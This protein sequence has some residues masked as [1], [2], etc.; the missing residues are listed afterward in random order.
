[1]SLP[2]VPYTTLHDM[3]FRKRSDIPWLWNSTFES[4]HKILALIAYVRMLLQNAQIG[5][6]S[7]A[8]GLKFGQFLNLHRNI[9]HMYANSEGSGETACR[10]V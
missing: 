3:L 7:A 5:V 4:A 8:P 10:F 2:G 1:M 6:S 9:M